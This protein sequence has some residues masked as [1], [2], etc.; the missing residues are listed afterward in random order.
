[1]EIK[2]KFIFFALIAMAIFVKVNAK[3]YLSEEATKARKI[4]EESEEFNGDSCAEILVGHRNNLLD[5]NYDEIDK[6]EILAQ[7]ESI[8]QELYQVEILLHEKL[9]QISRTERLS[10]DCMNSY[11]AF[12]LSM[13]YLKDFLIE[14]LDL[15][16]DQDEWLNNE[17]NVKKFKAN[18]YPLETGDVIVS[19]GDA[20]SS[21]G[22]AHMGRID[23]QFSH[24]AIIYKDPISKNIYTIESYI[25]KGVF[26]QTLEAFL[27]SG[28][29]RLVVLRHRDRALAKKAGDA[30]FKRI[31]NGKKIHY[32]YG[33]DY[34]DHQTIFCSEL[35]GFAYGALLNKKT[36]IP[37]QFTTFP[38][39]ENP[40]FFSMMGIEQKITYAPVDVLYDP[41]F[42][43]LAEWR[44]I[45]RLSA[46]RKQDAVARTLYTLMEDSAY[47]LVPSHNTKLTIDFGIFMRKI[48]FIGKLL[49]G[50]KLSAKA[51][52]KF[53][54][55]A[56]TLGH[57]GE[58]I[59]NELDLRANKIED[60]IKR[61]LLPK[62]L[63]E[64]VR[65]IKE[66]DYKNYLK[67]QEKTLSKKEKKKINVLFHKE[68]RP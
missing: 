65:E 50:E 20:I 22:I 59:F 64:L 12:D 21:A 66:D 67:Y 27:N 51:K 35:V 54:I 48:P 9:F 45:D 46:L 24:N 17:F 55:S 16:K 52:R 26:I 56:F 11:R 29:G 60:S 13:R 41:N 2:K 39:E 49:L 31:Q 25:E 10:D 33:F 57:V 3:I 68:F 58:L 42:I 6:E 62:E 53:L 36:D 23:G 18:D 8:V 7:G 61:P 5:L 63:R 28:I 1:M 37:Y 4:L 40:R 43:H 14:R 19:R 47:E 32:D 38:I 30:V 15:I 34:F 44:K